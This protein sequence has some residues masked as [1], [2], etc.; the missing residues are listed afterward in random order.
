M[1]LALLASVSLAVD[2]PSLEEI[3][4]R[5]RAHSIDL[6][7]Q[8]DAATLWPADWAALP[9]ERGCTL[10]P[11]EVLEGAVLGFAPGTNPLAA[12]QLLACRDLYAA[13][14]DAADTAWRALSRQRRRELQLLSPPDQVA[15]FDLRLQQRQQPNSLADFLLWRDLCVALAHAR[16]ILENSNG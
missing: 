8:S 5:A 4:A 6:Q 16:H 12:G 2:V 14:A 10:A 11:R 1:I 15:G 3:R 9:V 13:T 7:V